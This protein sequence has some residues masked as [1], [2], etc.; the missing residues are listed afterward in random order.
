MR[1]SPFSIFGKV[2]TLKQCRLNAKADKASKPQSSV[3]KKRQT[4]TTDANNDID[5][6][7]LAKSTSPITSLL[8]LI[9]L[10]ESK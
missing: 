4:E 10:L 2:K 5:A 6:V 3:H 8:S 1:Q 9:S 7:G